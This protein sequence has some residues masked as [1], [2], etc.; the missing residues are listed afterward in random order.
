MS[1]T[2]FQKTCKFYFAAPKFGYPIL[3]NKRETKV[4]CKTYFLQKKRVGTNRGQFRLIRD[5]G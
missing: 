5:I 3:G 4:V 1:A 2:K